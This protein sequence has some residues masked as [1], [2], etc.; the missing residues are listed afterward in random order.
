MPRTERSIRVVLAVATLLLVAP[1]ARV[2]AADDAAAVDFNRDIRPILSNNCLGCHGP[3]EAERQAGLRLD[4]IDAATRAADSGRAAIVPGQ[5]DKSE[6]VAR[7]NAT[8]DAERMPPP[9]SNKKLTDDQRPLLTRWIAEGAQANAHWSLVPPVRPE[10]PK[11]AEGTWPRN[12]LDYFVLARLEREGLA[13]SP[14]ADRLTLMRRLYLDLVGLLPTPD[15]A[16]AFAS[17]IR[18]DAYDALVDRL[19]DSPHYGE[20]WARRWLDLARYADTNGYEK[21]RPRSIWP[22]RDWVIRS[23]NADLPFDQ[24][25]IQQIAGDLLPGAGLSERVATGFHRNTMIN[26]EGGI[27]VEEFRFASVVDRVDTTGA[28][29]LG[30]TVGCAQC[31]THKFDPISQREYYGLFAFLNNADE[32]ELAV[33]QP[34]ITAARAEIE[35]QIANLTAQRNSKL[36][37][38]KFAAWVDETA[39]AARPWA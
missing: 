30:L 14:E 32:P 36:D 33:P 18:P 16:D 34:E 5:P 31:H 8:D 28:V 3:D 2:D 23:L 4:Q 19:L 27:D 21:D 11:V 39:R 6:L 35:S 24:F 15:E 37:P 13:P 17:D 9:D 7:I 1:L 12:E 26:E 22:Y 29:W 25:T 20:R 38:A 10:V